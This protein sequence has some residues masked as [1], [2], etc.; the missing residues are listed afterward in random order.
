MP[1]RRRNTADNS[2]S[3]PGAVYGPRS[4]LTSFLREQGIT[5][6][7][8]N[9]QYINRRQGTLQRS[10]SNSQQ[11]PA[12]PSGSATPG[13]GGPDDA[14]TS[15]TP[16]LAA[17]ED[18]EDEE[19]QQVAPSASGSA[20]TDANAE[21]GPSSGAKR[22]GKPLTAVQAK[23][24]KA[25]QAA[26]FG[27]EGDFTLA[28]KEMP[29]PKKGRYEERKPG[30]IKVCGE[31]GKKF[32]VSKYTATNPHGPG[33]LCAPCTSES[34]EDRATFPSAGPKG[35]KAAPKKKKAEK[36]VEETKF[37]E[38]KTLQQ[39]CLS[40]IASF[41]SSVETGAFSYL[42][43]KNLDRLAK[44]V[45]KNRA[46]DGENLKLFL[47]VGHRELKLYD[48]TNITDT[49]LSTIAPFCPHLESL[50]L[51]LCGRLDDDVIEA[52][53]TTSSSPGLKELKHLELYAPYLVTAKKWCEFFERRK[54]AGAEGLE[55]FRLRM[56]AR[57]NDLSLASLLSTSPGLH[58]LQLAELGKLTGS[59]LS[60]LY[61]LGTNAQLT[62]LDIAR[63]GT[64]QGQVLEDEDVV[65]LLKEVGSGLRE[66]VLDGNNLV[67][68]AT[69]TDGIAPYCRSLTSLSLSD[70]SLIDADGFHSLFTS[71]SPWSPAGLTLLN[72]HR[73]HDAL[74]PQSLSAL[75]AHSGKS[76]QHLNLHSCD[77]LE[78][79][80]GEEI[81]SKAPGL[82]VLD[83]SF[84]RSVDNFVVKALLD[85]AKELRT[86]FVHGNNRVTSD[87]PRKTGV[88]IRGLENA[89]HSEIPA[90][91]RWEY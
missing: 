61:P 90:G 89:V 51:L 52:W 59:S 31:C 67:T 49:S 33:L 64:P 74:T 80:L 42:G 22:K 60:L 14:T 27:E 56:S 54:E 79:E 81:A 20:S 55:T 44:I 43:P 21:A 62:S 3:T 76:L 66:L 7:G 37:T 11:D 28:G 68:S 24:A 41:I 65:K 9:V 39:S 50:S 30:A 71:S 10:N 48:C 69:L 53:L 25:K 83:V 5:G 23:K 32:T 18:G 8:A 17:G 86:L 87:V 70:L 12:S 13:A 78:A 72:A 47:E 77:L 91:I 15:V 63:L 26:E 2:S 4:A 75:L 38:I 45:S 35:R 57:F 73:L 6:P 29:A 58:T 34:I 36:A 16:V 85:G 1:P 88:Q 19:G 84:V 46:L 82:Q 40:I